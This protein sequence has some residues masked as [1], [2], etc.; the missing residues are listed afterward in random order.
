[1]RHHD[2]HNDAPAKRR[3]D[4]YRGPPVTLGDMRAH[5]CRRLLIYCS[6]GL[7]HHGATVDADRW[8]DDTAI[9]DLCRKAVCTRGGII[10]ADVRPDWQDRSE[11]GAKKKPRLVGPGASL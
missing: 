2:P 8:P 9:R 10:G 5:G 6:T 11:R 7:C 1:M 4:A 3:P